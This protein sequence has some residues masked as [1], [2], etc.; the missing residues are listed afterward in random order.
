MGFTSYRHN[1]RRL[2]L[3]CLNESQRA[4]IAAKLAN[5]EQGGDRKSKNQ[6]IN[7]DFDMTQQQAA[8]MFNVSRAT[9]ATVKA[10]EKA[11]K[12]APEK[13]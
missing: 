3:F 6:S 12:L 11:A 5:M 2:C 13:T 8:D 10:I 4:V 1:R 7:L 9:V